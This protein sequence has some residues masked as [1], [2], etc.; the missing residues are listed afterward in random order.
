MGGIKS[1]ISVSEVK[2]QYPDQ[3]KLVVNDLSFDLEP[4]T[5][6]AFVGQ[7]GCGKSTLMKLICGLIKPDSGTISVLGEVENLIS[8]ATW[9]PQGN[10]LLP[11]KSVMDNAILSAVLSGVEPELARAQANELLIKFGLEGTQNMW[12]ASLSGG[13]KRR[14][15][16]LRSFLV[17]KPVLVL[18][19][20]F[21]SLDQITRTNLNNWLE[22]VWLENKRTI[23]F[24]THDISEA[25]RLAD[26]VIVMSSEG[27]V[28]HIE[29]CLQ[30]RP[31]VQNLDK[32]FIDA[33][34]RITNLINN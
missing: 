16:L 7:S 34:I 26:N 22:S 10:L 27:K 12:P 32:N 5:V 15:A 33:E 18:D 3:K 6:T 24:V 9:H 30:L 14:V 31:R 11:W 17:P 4:D 2:F 8:V 29:K 23:L 13:M 20:P 1:L 28:I 21:S 19:E 25:L